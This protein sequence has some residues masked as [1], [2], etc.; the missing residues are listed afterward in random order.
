MTGMMPPSSY[1]PQDGALRIVPGMIDDM[2]ATV[3]AFM[4]GGM[5]LSFFSVI[6][7]M[8]SFDNKYMTF[9]GPM[10]LFC[11]SFIALLI[12]AQTYKNF[13]AKLAVLN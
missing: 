6:W 3:V 4:G 2:K 13:Q 11:Y 5:I 8:V 12:V 9:I 10:M 7:V 1:D